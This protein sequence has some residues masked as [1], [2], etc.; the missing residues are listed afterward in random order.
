MLTIRRYPLLLA[1]LLALPAGATHIVGGN[2]GWQYL[3]GD[4]FWVWVDIVRD[5][6][7][8]HLSSS[9][10]EIQPSC[11]GKVQYLSGTLSGAKDVTPVCDSACTAC[12]SGCGTTFG[13]QEYRLSAVAH[14]PAATCKSWRI[15]WQTCC[16]NN[17]ITTGPVGGFYLEAELDVSTREPNNSPTFFN[18]PVNIFCKNECAVYDPGLVATDVSAQG[19]NDSLVVYLSPAQTGRSAYVKYAQALQPPRA[20][21]L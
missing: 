1:L 3:G 7:G 16:R 4:S 20:T 10:L 6:Q 9:P 21:Y 13:L 12:T 19:T 18:N 17:A 11:G 2:I 8:Q 15:S 14:M 5:C